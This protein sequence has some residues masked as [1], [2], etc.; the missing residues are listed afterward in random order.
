M[1]FYLFVLECLAEFRALMSYYC[2]HTEFVQKILLKKFLQRVEQIKA[3]R[4]MKFQIYVTNF[5]KNLA[6]WFGK[7]NS[8]CGQ[9]TSTHTPF[10]TAI[11]GGFLPTRFI[12]KYTSDNFLLHIFIKFNNLKNLEYSH[13]IY[14]LIDFALWTCF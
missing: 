8:V 3:R 4:S 11:A 12:S 14:E 7:F 5:N 1:H 6:W 2:E 9:S 10:K 13:Q